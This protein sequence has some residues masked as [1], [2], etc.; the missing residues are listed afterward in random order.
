MWT[1][2]PCELSIEH[3]FPFVNEVLKIV[4][5]RSKKIFLT[6]IRTAFCRLLS[7][8]SALKLMYIII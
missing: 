4:K 3:L 7:D 8:H 6:G 1:I 2:C 5:F